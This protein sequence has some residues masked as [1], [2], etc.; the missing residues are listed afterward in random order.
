MWTRAGAKTAIYHSPVTALPSSLEHLS[1]LSEQVHQSSI[2]VQFKR[3][4]GRGAQGF[5][6][7]VLDSEDRHSCV[8]AFVTG[9]RLMRVRAEYLL[10]AS[11]LS[12][13]QSS[14][15]SYPKEGRASLARVC[16]ASI[17]RKLQ[18]AGRV[19]HP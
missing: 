18:A 2:D 7:V 8:N 17:S 14:K 3:L 1:N 15:R 5:G 13:I 12:A 6:H 10:S 9:S 4:D 16:A 19:R 11:G